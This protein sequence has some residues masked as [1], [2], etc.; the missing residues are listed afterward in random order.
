MAWLDQIKDG[1]CADADGAGGMTNWRPANDPT[2]CTDSATGTG[3]WWMTKLPQAQ[4]L[5]AEVASAPK[6]TNF[7]ADSTELFYLGLVAIVA[8][9]AWKTFVTKLFVAS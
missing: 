1:W 8:V 6:P 5:Y 9:W 7:Y 3:T 4:A 2:S